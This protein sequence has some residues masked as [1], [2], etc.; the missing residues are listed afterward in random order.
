[1]K[2]REGFV[3]N[4]SSSSFIVGSKEPI[5]K[6]YLESIAN[7][8]NNI[9]KFFLKAMLTY[10]AE[11]VSVTTKEEIFKYGEPDSEYVKKA[12]S[13]KYLYILSVCNDDGDSISNIL[14]DNH[15]EV[16]LVDCEDMII[17]SN[18]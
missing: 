9:F 5:T 16:L 3:S 18:E 13:F 10:I 1:M 8:E 4:S 2:I 11:N 12:L 15:H 6:E 14:Y 7:P 17:T